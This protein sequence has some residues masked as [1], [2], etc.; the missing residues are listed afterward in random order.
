MR[1]AS[2]RR[3]SPDDGRTLPVPAS[4]GF[5]LWR[6]ARKPPLN[7]FSETAR[8]ERANTDF[9]HAATLSLSL[10]LARSLSPPL[11]SLL[12]DRAA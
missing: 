6:I 11:S 12:D 1:G 2:P 4:D 5:P 10:S 3:E 9:Q 8:G 7:V